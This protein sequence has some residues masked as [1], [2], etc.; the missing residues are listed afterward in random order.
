MS[1]DYLGVDFLVPGPFFFS[2]HG[3]SPLAHSLEGKECIRQTH[4]SL[5]YF[6]KGLKSKLM[7]DG[8]NIKPGL[9]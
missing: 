1:A 9:K 6:S 2:S 7:G 5:H 4:S 8:R 3:L